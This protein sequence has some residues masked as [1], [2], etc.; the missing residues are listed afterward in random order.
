MQDCTRSSSDLLRNANNFWQKAHPHVATS[1]LFLSWTFWCQL[2]ISEC[3]FTHPTGQF[4]CSQSWNKQ[5]HRYQYS[6]YL[7]LFYFREIVIFLSVKEGGLLSWLHQ[8]NFNAMK[9]L[10][11]H[12]KWWQKIINTGRPD[13][14]RLG[15]KDILELF[16]I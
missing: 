4:T 10:V 8:L 11:I 9:G 2:R 14:V 12:I 15:S 7:F 16:F 1:R 13:A 5:V 3:T 6:V